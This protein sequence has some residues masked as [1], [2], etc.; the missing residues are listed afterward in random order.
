MKDAGRSVQSL[1]GPARSFGQEVVASAR[2]CPQFR[3]TAGGCRRISSWAVRRDFQPDLMLASGG[4]TYIFELKAFRNHPGSIVVRALAVAPS[5]RTDTPRRTQARRCCPRRGR[6]RQCRGSP[7]RPSDLEADLPAW[8]A[9]LA[10]ELRRGC[11]PKQQ[12]FDVGLEAARD[13][14]ESA[15]ALRCGAASGNGVPERSR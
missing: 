9:A 14:I 4:T 13:L 15:S 7:G 8:A 11:S 1:P 3:A 12:A 5:R 6:R 2:A 10:A